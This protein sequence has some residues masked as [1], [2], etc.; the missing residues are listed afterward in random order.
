MVFKHADKKLAGT[1]VGWAAAAAC[2]AAGIFYINSIC[3]AQ[4]FSYA[5]CERRGDLLCR[6]PRC[7]R[8]GA[9]YA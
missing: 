5:L 7:R 6:E 4:P 8:R 1:V 9:S 2:L 3:S